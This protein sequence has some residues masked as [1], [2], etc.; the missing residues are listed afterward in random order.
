MKATQLLV[1]GSH[2][3]A[4]QYLSEQL[5]N[6]LPIATIDAHRCE[7]RLYPSQGS[8][9]V[10]L[11]DTGAPGFDVAEFLQLVRQSGSG[12]RVLLLGS[13]SNPESI[14]GW[15]RRGINGYLYFPEVPQKLFSAIKVVSEGGFWIPAQILSHL[16]RISEVVE[17]CAATHYTS[18]LPVL[19]SCTDGCIRPVLTKL[20]RIR[21]WLEAGIPS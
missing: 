17:N 5:G 4:R 18:R 3:L 20:T 10:V 8:P 13:E 7:G 6:T 14:L 2:P 11:V 9:T 16:L 19:F 15:F 21:F 1:V 12:D